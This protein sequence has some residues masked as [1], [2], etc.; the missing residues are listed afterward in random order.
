MLITGL[1]ASGWLESDIIKL[2]QPFGTPSDIIMAAQIGKVSANAVS[3]E[4]E[5]TVTKVEN[6]SPKSI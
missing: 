1:P 3:S 4:E 5:K 6:P 2:V